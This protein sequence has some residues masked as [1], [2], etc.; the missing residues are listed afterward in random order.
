MT[1][2]HGA[3]DLLRWK[4]ARHE[5][6]LA[7][8]RAER[9]VEQ[10]RGQLRDAPVDAMTA[11]EIAAVELV[12]ESAAVHQAE[13]PAG[14]VVIELER[15]LLAALRAPSVAGFAGRRDAVHAELE[16]L[17]IAD[18]RV[19]RARIASPQPQDELAGEIWKLGRALRQEVAS[20]IENVDRRKARERAAAARG[21]KTDRAPEP[22][23]VD[24]TLRRA[25][26][27]G[28]SE[29]DL[30]AVIATLDGG[31]RR[32]LAM[33]LRTYRPGSGDD[34]AARF[35]AL[36]GAVRQRVLVELASERATDPMGPPLAGHPGSVFGLT[37]QVPAGPTA[38]DIATQVDRA[39]QLATGLFA[40]VRAKADVYLKQHEVQ[41]WDVVA[42]YLERVSFPSPSPRAVWRDD[43]AFAAATVE[44]LST[45]H[46][47]DRR[48]A[49]LEVL[50]PA[51][52]YAALEALVPISDAWIPTVGSAL[53]QLFE[54]AIVASLARLGPRWVDL[55]EHHP[56]P[57]GLAD[58][59]QPLVAAAALVSSAPIDR[60]VREGMT[61]G[62]ALALVGVAS[63]SDGVRPLRPVTLEWQGARDPQ[64]WNW[65][66]VSSP[67]DATAEEVAAALWTSDHATEHAYGLTASGSFFGVPASW[68]RQF[69]AAKAFAPTGHDATAS[70]QLVDLAAG[71]HAD[72]LALD[73]AA[74]APRA[75]RRLG[76]VT[77]LLDDVRIQ[78]GH[79]VQLFAPWG[80]DA[81]IATAIHW[82][83]GK[84]HE[85]TAAHDDERTTWAPIIADQKER[86]YRIA[87]AVRDLATS[88]KS[89]PMKRVLAFYAR[90]TATSFLGAAS[91]RL[92]ASAVQEQTMLMLGAVRASTNDLAVVVGDGAGLDSTQVAHAEEI[93]SEARLLQTSTLAGKAV[94]PDDVE[95]I[96]L[97]TQELALHLRI[98]QI[99]HQ[100]H[101][102]SAAAAQATDGKIALAV[103]A[104]PGRFHDLVPMTAEFENHLQMVESSW[105]YDV[106][107]ASQVRDPDEYGRQMLK[108]RRA[109]LATAQARFAAI[110]TDDG[111]TTFL[112][113]GASVIEHELRV[114]GWVTACVQLLVLIGVGMF[115]NAAGSVVAETIAGWGA[116][117]EAV[118]SVTMLARAAR[119]LGRFGGL[120]T[121][122]AINTAGQRMFKQPGDDT[123]F[124]AG[125][126]E[127]ALMSFGSNVI[128]SRIG[129]SLEFAK[130][131]ERSTGSLW[132]ST[133]VAGAVMLAKGVTITSHVIINAAT[134]YVAHQIVKRGHAEPSNATL[135]EWFM[136]GAA[137]AIGRY[138]HGQIGGRR[139]LYAKLATLHEL[140]ASQRLLRDGDALLARATAVEAAPGDHDALELLARQRALLADE[141]VVLEAAASSDPAKLRALDLTAPTLRGM[142]R[143]AQATLVELDATDLV[144][145]PLRSAHLDELVPGE[146]WKGTPAQIDAA[147]AAAGRARIPVEAERGADGVWRIKLGAREVTVHEATSSVS[148]VR[149]TTNARQST[150]A[151]SSNA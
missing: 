27:D 84:Q 150:D 112:Q 93:A 32:A 6:D 110:K 73:A 46:L 38:A 64:M 138:V 14:Y 18:L 49:L 98:E 127:N 11:L 95:R 67:S 23:T 113:H 81:D 39:V 9:Q 5:A 106:S 21:P 105:T 131:I 24:T 107:G 15:E 83:T 78:L 74:H 139:E 48:E 50:Y 19:L 82:V 44:K 142:K 86:V 137:V 87:D 103:A 63:K 100:L 51:N 40:P 60:A 58:E 104:F 10:T 29:V 34:I 26:E 42:R 114:V 47:F 53:G 121:E 69:A 79:L 118:E 120:A 151:Q 128:L 71:T 17:S 135:T 22:E 16:Q 85:L 90:A 111:L 97:S 133:K 126:A 132:A 72:E 109:A 119:T 70:E 30:L 101:A 123:S 130:D 59:N 65:V 41:A 55:A 37:G 117:A 66:R 145:L 1:A 96:T 122:A 147:I 136:Q 33:R 148:E 62:G 115:A 102:L 99:R 76:P 88:A 12:A 146:V 35:T 116:S 13:A 54:Q 91:E 52:P 125:M 129:S 57:A 143:F 8:T 92:I 144:E 2:A 36:D 4:Q 89:A 20:F 31:A 25:V 7:I 3:N 108:L 141:I 80:L 56:E 140:E 94:D 134:A 149:A 77:G 75:K 61:V 43:V 28:N 68:A 124:V 45:M